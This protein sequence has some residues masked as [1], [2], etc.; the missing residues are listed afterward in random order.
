M[1]GAGGHLPSFGLTGRTILVTG[2]GR[3]LGKGIALA[4]VEAGATVVAVSRSSAELAETASA[5]S[6]GSVRPVPWDVT[7]TGSLDALVE[8]AEA[9]GGPLDGVVHAAGAQHRESADAFVEADWRRIVAVDL[10]APFFLSTAIHRSQRERGAAGSHVLIGS[11]ASSIGL[12]NMAAYGAAK[13]GLLGVVRSLSVEWAPSGTRVNCLAPG[14]FLT[15]QTRE[16]LADER[17]TARINARIP[18]GRLGTVQELAGVA[19]FLLSDAASYITG[20]IVNVD[21]GWLGS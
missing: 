9:V 8:L 1:S 17:N 2:A 4:L 14:Y 5:A 10:E 20:Q 3:G 12:P 21:G 6:V 19:A 16:L 13:A 11:L 18:M 7:D 15:S